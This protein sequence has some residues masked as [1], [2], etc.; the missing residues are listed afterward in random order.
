MEKPAQSS[1]DKKW[2]AVVNCDKNYDGLFFYGVKTTGV[3]C[4][5]S[6]RSKTPERV[7]VHFFDNVN[8][9]IKAGF[10]ACKRCRP[11]ILVF[12]PDVDLLN[13]AKALCNKNFDKSIDLNYISKQLGVSKNLL[14]RLFKQHVGLTPILYINMLRVNKASDLLTHTDIDIMEIAYLTG[15]KSLSNFYKCFKEQTGLKPIEYRKINTGR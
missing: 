4:R 3:F 1:E 9:A 5:P 6:C 2:Q 11:D 13:Q 8:D 12:E 7:N 15:F 14:I 10:R